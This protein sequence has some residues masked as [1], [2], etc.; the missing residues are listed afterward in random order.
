[1]SPEFRKAEPANPA[2]PERP[3]FV[4]ELQIARVGDSQIRERLEEKR[5]A[6][7]DA[8]DSIVLA[9]QI[10]RKQLTETERLLGLAPEARAP[11]TIIAAVNA[12]EQKKWRAETCMRLIR[13]HGPMRASQIHQLIIAAC[14]PPSNRKAGTQQATLMCLRGNDDLFTY[15]Q[16]NKLWSL[17]K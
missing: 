16:P 8:I 9:Y 12:R 1:M 15:D 2:A 14:Q 7:L 11:R 10:A 17:K 5:R 6:Q 13:T 4:A 3:T